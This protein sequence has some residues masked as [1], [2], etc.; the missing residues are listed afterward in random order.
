MKVAALAMSRRAYNEA[1][2]A[3][4]AAMKIVPDDILAS[5]GASKAR[6][7]KAMLEGQQALGLRKKNEAIQA[8]EAALAEKPGDPQANLGLR[9]ARAIQE[10]PNRKPRSASRSDPKE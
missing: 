4:E 5:A 10:D 1:I 9:Q 2:A 8:F 3:Y 7:A 6:Y